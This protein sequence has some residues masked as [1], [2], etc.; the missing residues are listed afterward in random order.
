MFGYITPLY[1]ELKVKEYYYFKSYYCGLCHTIKKNYG[2]LPRITLNYDL[3]FISFLLDGLIDKP[4]KTKQIHCLKHL[5]TEI[6][7]CEPTDALN[8]ISD[9]NII[10]SN[11]KLKDDII[12]DGNL[13][14][15]LLYAFSSC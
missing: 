11:L 3:T 4:L 9:L 10:I 12:D 5:N 2:N 7:I 6:S 14:S 13:K 15:I 8:Y 1:N